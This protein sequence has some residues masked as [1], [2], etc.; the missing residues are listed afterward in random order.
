[1]KSKL[2]PLVI[3][4]ALFCLSV[5]LPNSCMS[6]ENTTPIKWYSYD[7]GMARAKE[8]HKKVF[9]NFYADWCGFCKKMDNGTF[10]DS[11]VVDYLQKN[12]ISIKVNSDKQKEIAASY[13]V[14]GLPTSWFLAD[15]GEKISSLPRYS[16]PEE[17]INIL[18]FINTESYQKMKYSDFVKNM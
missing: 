11:A 5:W 18:K 3:L 17:L 6:S 15:D 2:I 8:T 10:K 9:L 7:D 13:Y 1:M 16:P 4:L 14:R 12:F